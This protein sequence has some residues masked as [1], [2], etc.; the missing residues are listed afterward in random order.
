MQQRLVV[1]IGEHCFVVTNDYQYFKNLDYVFHVGVQEPLSLKL[2]WSNGLEWTTL[3]TTETLIL[4]QGPQTTS[5][6]L[7]T[8]TYDAQK[9]FNP[10]YRGIMAMGRITELKFEGILQDVW[11]AFERSHGHRIV[12]K[13]RLGLGAQSCCT[14]LGRAQ[15]IVTDNEKGNRTYTWLAAVEEGKERDAFLLSPRT[16]EDWETHAREAKELALIKNP[17]SPRSEVVAE[18]DSDIFENKRR[19]LPVVLRDADKEMQLQFFN[20]LEAG[21]YVESSHVLWSQS[22]KPERRSLRGAKEPAGVGGT[23]VLRLTP[24]MEA[25]VWLQ[26][27]EKSVIRIS[28]EVQNYTKTLAQMGEGLPPKTI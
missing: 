9:R 18:I 12:C 22:L 11:N 1:H 4:N 8:V 3:Y 21:N 7:F 2:S 6:S 24:H 16:Q 27:E 10:A 13:L 5:S 14:Y 28:L 17:T 23:L 19:V 20:L 26:K 25:K 15:H